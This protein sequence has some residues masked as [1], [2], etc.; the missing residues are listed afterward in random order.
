MTPGEIKG[1]NTALGAPKNWDAETQGECAVLKVRTGAG[2]MESAWYP[3]DE[4]KVAI[5]AGRPV[6]LTVWG[7][8]HPPVSL[9]AEPGPPAAIAEGDTLNMPLCLF[10]HRA[11][12]LLAEEQLKA[13]PNNALV[14]FI[15]DAIRLARENER[16]ARAP[17]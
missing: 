7:A 2:I 3:S 4:E 16:M 10:E 5:A 14:A 11:G 9:N 8:T 12:V 17:L 13:S 1:A 15:C 6:I